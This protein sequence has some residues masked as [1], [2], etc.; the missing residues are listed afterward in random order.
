VTIVSEFV[1][2]LQTLLDHAIAMCKP[3][4]LPLWKVLREIPVGYLAGAVAAFVA[5]TWI[6]SALEERRRRREREEAQRLQRE[7]KER[8]RE[9]Q[10]RRRLAWEEVE[11]E[12]YQEAVERYEREV[13]QF[14][15]R[16]RD[17]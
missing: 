11:H 3:L 7:R 5:W 9:R 14:E 2:L 13:E 1:E 6:A 17:E 15:K 8:E 4:A 16:L 12:K 10:E